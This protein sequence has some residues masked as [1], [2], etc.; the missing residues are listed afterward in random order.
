MAEGETSACG[1]GGACGCGRAP[2]ETA[3]PEVKLLAWSLWEAELR[4]A[5]GSFWSTALALDV[6]ARCG[7]NDSA[8]HALAMDF[9]AALHVTARDVMGGA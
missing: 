6:C 3:H 2:M 5:S 4:S 8:E 7:N 1:C 9:L